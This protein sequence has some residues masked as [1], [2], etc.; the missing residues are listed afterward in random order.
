M[1]SF[2]KYNNTYKADCI[3]RN[4]D[5]SHALALDFGVNKFV[6]AASSH[7]K[8][9]IIDGRRLKSIKDK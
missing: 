5:K 2:L 1:Q 8:S 9:F 7:W 3:Q 4:L 6:T